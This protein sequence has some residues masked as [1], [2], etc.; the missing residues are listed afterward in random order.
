MAWVLMVES[1]LGAELFAVVPDASL[2][3]AAIETASAPA[4]AT[5][6]IRVHR[7]VFTVELLLLGG[8]PA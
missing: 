7:V 2:L 8:F 4:A 3:Q 5:A 1:G 6:E